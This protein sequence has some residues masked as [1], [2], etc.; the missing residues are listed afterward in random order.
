MADKKSE[1]IVLKLCKKRFGYVMFIGGA[2]CLQNFV[3][4]LFSTMPRRKEV[5]NEEFM[6][7]NFGTTHTMFMGSDWPCPKWGYPDTGAGFYSRKLPYYHWFKFNCG[8][9]IHNNS[10]EH[11][12]FL[13]PM[14]FV[15]G[16]F[17]PRTTIAMGVTIMLGR[18]LYR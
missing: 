14:F 6:N 13:M 17:I 2:L 5:F 8:Q 12:S 18:E 9:R 7:P 4:G 11:M 15:S 10:L 3:T 16:L 1:E